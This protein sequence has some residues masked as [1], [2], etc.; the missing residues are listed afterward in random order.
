MP[1]EN[2]LT[3]DPANVR[4]RTRTTAIALGAS[5]V[6]T[7]LF[8]VY[9]FVQKAEAEKQRA[10]AANYQKLAADL[11]DHEQQ[12]IADLREEIDSLK[13]SCNGVKPE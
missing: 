2:S 12:V 3:P 1:M 8:L 10:L 5:V 9:A 7:L 13:N 6:I 4:K 11:H